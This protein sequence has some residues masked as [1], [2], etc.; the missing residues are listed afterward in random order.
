MDD[1]GSGDSDDEADESDEDDAI[2]AANQD[3]QPKI[4]VVGTMLC[5]YESILHCR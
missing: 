3:V 5:T 2:G 4:A 1:T